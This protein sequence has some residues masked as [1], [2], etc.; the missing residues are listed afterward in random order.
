MPADAP[1]KLPPL[2]I[3]R[4]LDSFRRRL[5]RVE[6]RL[7]PPFVSILDTM[8][9]AWVAQGVYVVTKLGVV[10]AL[11]DGP[12]R[13]D[14]IAA[15]VGADADALGRL[16]RALASHGMFTQRRDGRFG[17]SPLSESLLADA[18]DSAR[19]MV[20]FWGDPLH[21]EHWGHLSY[22]V[23]TGQSAIEKLRGKPAFDWL[24]EVPELGAV[25]N[26]GMTSMSTMET[27]LVVAAYDFSR[28]NTVVDVG[29]GHG[30]LLGAVLQKWPTIRGILF[31]FAS[32]VDGA[33]AVLEQA[34]V[35]ERCEMVGGSFFE[36]VPTGGD[37]Y[38][39]KHIIHDWSD[40]DAR[41]I[42]RNV[43]EAMKPAAT[44]VLVEMVVPADDREHMAKMLDLEMLVSL[45]GRERTE[46]EYVELLRQAGFRHRRTVGTVGPASIV[47]AVAV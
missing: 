13:A 34:G 22:S 11:R 36:S 28:F 35:L 44:L 46:A 39:L 12:L 4:A 7:Q 29:G 19:G 14:A 30:M 15:R 16:L 42:L 47:E 1:A 37:V 6:R 8:T 33:P 20:L 45:A 18:P 40:D 10:D 31:D 24:P 2:R 17:L 27:P 5:R 25:F 21:W 32:V 3:A 41:R 23:Q 38:I 43:R 26:D 9:S